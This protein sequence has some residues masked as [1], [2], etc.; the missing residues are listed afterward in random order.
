M[1]DLKYGLQ[2]G[3]AT[4]PGVTCEEWRWGNNRVTDMTLTWPDRN[5]DTLVGIELNL[6][7][8]RNWKAGKTE[9]LYSR[10]ENFSYQND[11][12]LFFGFASSQE[13]NGTSLDNVG[14][15]TYDRQQFN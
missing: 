14:I 5:N 11:R 1:D 12:E 7:D 9:G 2:H 4:G 3:Y 6:N 13:E 8:N 10:T 15:V